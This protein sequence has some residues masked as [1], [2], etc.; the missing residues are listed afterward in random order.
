LRRPHVAAKTQFLGSDI[1]YHLNEW[2]ALL[3]GV[4]SQLSGRWLKTHG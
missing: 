4:Y 3:D 1:G 2:R